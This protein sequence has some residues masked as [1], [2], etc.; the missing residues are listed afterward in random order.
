MGHPGGYQNAPQAAL[1]LGRVLNLDLPSAVTTDCT[2][3]GG[4]SGGPLFNMQ[5]EVVG[6]HSRIGGALTANLHVPVNTYVEE[7]DRLVKGDHWGH[8]PGQEPFLGVQGDADRTDATITHVFS[9]SPAERGGIRPGDL[10]VN[11]AGEPVSDFDGL[12]RLV[13]QQD[14]GNVVEVEVIRERKTL[15]LQITIGRLPG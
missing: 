10:V 2:L 8:I 14:P 9:R 12:K 6:I 4:D 13:E 11:F 7:W 15:R 1:R 3:I 5:G